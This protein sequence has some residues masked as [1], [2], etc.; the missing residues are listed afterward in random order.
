MGLTGALEQETQYVSRDED[1]S[2]PLLW[3]Q[4]VSLAINEQNDAPE[5]NVYGCSEERG[6][7][8]DEQR[9]HDEGAEGPEVFVR[10]DSADIACH[11]NFVELVFMVLIWAVCNVQN[12]PITSGMKYHVFFFIN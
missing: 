2:E 6:S 11:F 10:D 9:L 5:N 7:D 4:R 12:P 1:L 3:N 8:E